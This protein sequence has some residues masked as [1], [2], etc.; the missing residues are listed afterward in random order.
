MNC[1]IIFIGEMY[2]YVEN[3]FDINGYRW[4]GFNRRDIYVNV[5][6]IFGWCRNFSQKLVDRLI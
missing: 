2:L 4:F 3:V 6:K 1:D 5:F